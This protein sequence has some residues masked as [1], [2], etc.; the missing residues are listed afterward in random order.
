L[1]ISF[2]DLSGRIRPPNA[3]VASLRLTCFNGDLPSRLPIGVDEKGDFDLTA[4]GPVRRV[5]CLVRPT[6]VIQP[7][8]GKP[9]LWR[10]V[11]ALSL[12]HLSL[13]EDG[14]EALC[15]LLRLHNPGDSAA[16]DRQ[17]QGVAN[18][19]SA[20]AFARVPTE[21][22]LAFARGR[23]VEIEFDEE[24][25]PG[26]GMFLFASILERFLAMHATMNSFVQMGVRSR[27][28]KKIVREWQ[29]RAGVRTLL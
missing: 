23:R 24:F 12:N 1:Y 19:S 29:P 2:A 17:I 5:L 7:P 6:P 25:F 14:R 9:L 13:V 10:L 27:Q 18:V 26:G 16:G 11:S 3:E 21:Q 4:G 20:P 22:G 8:L 15:E 28:R